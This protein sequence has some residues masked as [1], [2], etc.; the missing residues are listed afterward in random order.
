[1]EPFKVDS[2]QFQHWPLAIILV[3]FLILALFYSFVLPLGEVSDANAHFALVRFIAEH[4][5]PPL[6][7][8]EQSEVGY[9]GDASPLYHSLVAFLTQYVDVSDLPELPQVHQKPKRTIPDD[10]RVDMT[11]FHTEDEAFPFRGIVLAWHLARLVSIPLGVATIVGVYLIVL[12]LYPNRR[13]FALAAA[14]FVAFVPRFV[15]S[16]SVL[17]D[18]NLVWPLI[19]FALYYLIRIIQGDQRRRTLVILGILMGLATLTKYHSLVLVFEMTLIMLILAYQKDWGWQTLVRRWGWC[20]LAFTLITAWWFAFLIIRF[21]EVKSLGSVSGL[22]APFGDP[23]I[24]FGVDRFFEADGSLI[25]Q[26]AWFDWADL[27]FRTFW[28]DYSGIYEG[29]QAEGKLAIYWGVYAIIGLVTLVAVLGLVKY[30]WTYFVTN[31]QLRHQRRPWRLEIAVLVFHLFIYLGIVLVRRIMLPLPATAQGRHLY[32]ALVSIALFLV[33]GLNE[34]LRSFR[35]K[36]SRFSIRSQTAGDKTL[37]V[38]ISGTLLAFSLFALLFFVGP[39][40]F[41]YL[42]L[43]TID[44]D[45]VSISQRLNATFVDGVN[46]VGYNLGASAVEAGEV[47]PVTLYWYVKEELRRDYLISMCL[48][49]EGDTPVVCRKGHPVD[50]RYPMRAWEEDY[51]VRDEVYLPIPACLSP[52][53]YKLTLTVLPL[54]LDTAF[55]VV[56]E[57]VQEVQPVTLGWVSLMAG[58]QPPAE[59]FDLW[60]GETRY[61]YRTFG[62]IFDNQEMITLRQLRQALTVI[63]YQPIVE[64]PVRVNTWRGR[65]NVVS[66]ILGAKAEGQIGRVSPINSF[67]VP[68]SS[69][70]EVAPTI[71]YN[72]SDGLTVTTHNFVVDPGIKPESSPLLLGERRNLKLQVQ[73]MTRQRNFSLPRHISTELDASFA[74]EVELLGYDMDL[75]SRLPGDTIEI[76][77]Y[78]RTLRTMSHRYTGSFHLLDNAVT[79]WG[80]FD[81]PLGRPYWNLLWTPGEIID[82]VYPLRVAPHTPP[83]LYAIEFGVYRYEKGNFHFLSIMRSTDVEPAKHLIFGQVRVLD[84]DRMKLPE[85][86]IMV[87]LGEGIQLSGFD[88]SGESLSADRP[89]NLALHWQTTDQ[90]TTDYTVFTQL[91]GPDGQVWGQQ[92]NQPQDGRYPTSW[93]QTNDKIVDRYQIPLKAGAPAGEYQLLVGMYILQTGERLQAVDPNGQPLPDNAIQLAT[94]TLK[95]NMLQ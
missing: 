47:L 32:P 77:L 94:L 24:A 85:N 82:E 44:P 2:R 49:D 55:T 71:I 29:L 57:T 35:R 33:L 54:R 87:K 73:V 43:V 8:E 72:C 50:G 45:E 80:Q 95:K 91:I 21:N 48:H 64:D 30:V 5:R 36:S 53:D 15:I 16:S 79:M 41:P 65:T 20:M 67:L 61:P 7:L 89:L 70:P 74:G 23:V 17:N 37:M 86:P 27:I 19:T 81:R 90:P 40:Y 56:D 1:M 66:K 28:F 9:K 84:P 88:L 14:G 68:G 60:V 78:W 31:K 26:S 13:Y 52:G 3:I 10:G 22:L 42:P 62:R 34:F 12:T 46:F 38:S 69:W 83:G 93:W 59:G 92:D 58:R 39:V 25:R 63:D 76:T 4:K 11:L 18:D 6:T 75:S 51:L